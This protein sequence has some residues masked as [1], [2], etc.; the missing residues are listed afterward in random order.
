MS[1][2]DKSMILINGL[3]PDTEGGYKDTFKMIPTRLNCPYNEAIYDTAEQV[4]FVVSK[5]KKDNL[6]RMKNDKDVVIEKYYEYHI[7]THG[8]IVNFIK[9][10][11]SNDEGFDYLRYMN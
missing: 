9:M 5:E 6:H 4:L 7:T 11:C 8:E 2:E 10:F 3:Q 1:T